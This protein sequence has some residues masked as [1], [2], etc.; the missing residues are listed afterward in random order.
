MTT[1]NVE[2]E[3]TKLE[4]DYWQ[5]IKDRDAAVAMKLT[6]RSLRARPQVLLELYFL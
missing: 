3:L 1:A 5:A 2:K 4:N 6:G